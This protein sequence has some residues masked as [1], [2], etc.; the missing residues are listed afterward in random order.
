MLGRRYNSLR[1]ASTP[2]SCLSSNIVASFLARSTNPPYRLASSARAHARGYSK[3]TNSPW[4]LNFKCECERSELVFR[5]P[6]RASARVGAG[7][8]STL[9]LMEVADSGTAA[10]L[11]V[12]LTLHKRAL[13]SGLRLGVSRQRANKRI[14]FWQSRLAAR[15]RSRRMGLDEAF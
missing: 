5:A 8:T 14:V 7:E 15:I 4:K 3:T 9:V 6:A 12:R 2:G 1:K 11:I 10:R 13:K